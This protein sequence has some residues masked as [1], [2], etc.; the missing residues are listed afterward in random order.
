M[1]TNNT[2]NIIVSIQ[3]NNN[4]ISNKLIFIFSNIQIWFSIFVPKICPMIDPTSSHRKS[5]PR[6]PFH[7]SILNKPL[8][9]LIHTDTQ[10]FAMIVD[11]LKQYEPFSIPFLHKVSKRDVPSY[12]DFIKHPMDLGTLQ[13]NLKKYDRESFKNDLTLI[14]DNCVFFNGPSI[15]TDYAEKMRE[16]SNYLWDFLFNK[17]TKIENSEDPN[18]FLETINLSED[19]EREEI[20]LD[21]VKFEYQN[22]LEL[23]HFTKRIRYSMDVKL[24]KYES[25]RILEQVI[26]VLIGAMGYV[27]VETAAVKILADVVYNLLLKQCEKS[28]DGLSAEMLNINKKDFEIVKLPVNNTNMEID[29]ECDLKVDED[30]K[31]NTEASNEEDF[32]DNSDENNIIEENEVEGASHSQ[33]SNQNSQFD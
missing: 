17:E 32:K 21:F 10:L 20:E 29:D 30:E 25:L 9:A 23:G 27:Y 12:H 18:Y 13:K 26:V 24:G 1:I 4:A 3:I 22:I 16:R 2:L 33:M 31:A 5:I 7:L 11:S 15:Y 6:L 8:T 19:I 28:N 14:W